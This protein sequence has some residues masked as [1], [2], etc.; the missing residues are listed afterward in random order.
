MTKKKLMAFAKERGFIFD[1]EKYHNGGYKA[2]NK[3]GV[4][5]KSFTLEGLKRMIDKYLTEKNK[6]KLMKF[7][8]NDEISIKNFK[9]KYAHK[10]VL[11]KIENDVIIVDGIYLYYYKDIESIEKI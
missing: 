11:N 3:N 10:G 7:N 5:C 8:I 6:E 2:K 9:D 1:G 4:V